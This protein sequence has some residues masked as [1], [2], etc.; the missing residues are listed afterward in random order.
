MSRTPIRDHRNHSSKPHTSA[1]IS[2]YTSHYHIS[3]SNNRRCR[4]SEVK[5]KWNP[6]AHVRDSPHPDHEN[7]KPKDENHDTHDHERPP[8]SQLNRSSRTTPRKP[9]TIPSGTSKTNSKNR[10]GRSSRR[11]CTPSE[12]TDSSPSDPATHPERHTPPLSQPSGG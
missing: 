5:P 10:L 8:P 2:C 11:Y 9:D 4:C 6:F 12:S 3:A 7:R 1:Q